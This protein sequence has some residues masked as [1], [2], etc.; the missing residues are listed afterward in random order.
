MRS[1]ALAL[2]HQS[3]GV[4]FGV[5][6]PERS[7][8]RGFDRCS[9]TQCQSRLAT[10]RLASDPTRDLRGA[11]TSPTATHYGAITDAKKAGGLLCAIND[12]A[13]G[14]IAGIMQS[15][16]GASFAE[17]YRKAESARRPCSIGRIPI[18]GRRYKS[19]GPGASPNHSNH[20]A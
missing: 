1:P 14:A 16:D 20:S 3:L 9:H 2:S 12:Y 5:Q 8:T 18:R 7:G 15:E 19:C 4:R 13:G 11:L 6:S 10:A 17:D